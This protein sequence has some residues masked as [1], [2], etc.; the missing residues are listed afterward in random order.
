M[1]I[2]RNTITIVVYAKKTTV[3]LMDTVDVATKTI[4]LQSGI[5]EDCVVMMTNI[6]AEPDWITI[7][8]NQKIPTT[9]ICQK[10]NKEQTISM[11]YSKQSFPKYK[12]YTNM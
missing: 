2:M 10:I 11:I 6:L 1:K 4:Q 5:I 8:C 7:P 3:F 12:K 9:L